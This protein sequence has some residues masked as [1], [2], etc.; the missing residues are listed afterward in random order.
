MIIIKPIIEYILNFSFNII[1]VQTNE[2]NGV[3]YAILEILAVS[4]F[5]NASAHVVKAIAF[6]NTPI[7][8]RPKN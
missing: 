2:I 7:H 5:S 4:P 1:L 8:S 6:V 3:M